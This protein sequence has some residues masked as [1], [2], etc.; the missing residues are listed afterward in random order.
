MNRLKLSHTAQLVL[1]VLAVSGFLVL[2]GNLNQ[3]QAQTVKTATKNTT[4]WEWSDDGWRRRVEIQGKAEFNEDYSDITGL[5]ED[6][7]MRLEEDLN[8]RS[9]RL[10]VRRVASGELVRR[11]F[12]NGE[13]RALDQDGRKWV[14][15]LL[16]TAVKQGGIDPEGRVK[17][18]LRKGGVNGVLEEIASIKGDHAK[19]I[20]F[21]ALLKNDSLKR[22][23]LQHVLEATRTQI[24]SDHTKANLLKQSADLFLDDS[25]LSESYFEAISTIDSDYEQRQTLSALLQKT[26][27][28]EAALAQ[29]LDSL[30]T[31]SSDYEKANLLKQGADS[32]LSHST[33]GKS[34]FKVV[35]TINSDYEHRQILSALLKKK[36][37]SAAV[38]AQ[39]LDSLAT[40]SSDHE[41][42]T[43]LLEASGLY[44]GDA[45]LRNAFL[46][47]TDTIK[48]EHE[49]GRVL[50]ALLRNKQIG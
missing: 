47:A 16:L 34:F 7:F 30:A 17:T 39:M 45:R 38:L 23:D 19:Y 42:A 3:V 15:G 9:Q 21:Q 2:P 36:N 4:R 44:T 26:N 22:S 35:A 49:R 33:L 37:L 12:V 50:S 40:I 31:I 11:Y 43:F 8:G 48:S 6:G 28:T 20:Y 10:E 18:L 24:R 5:S 25:T 46:K 14:A 27:L 1:F 29:M 41:K 13:S 32:F